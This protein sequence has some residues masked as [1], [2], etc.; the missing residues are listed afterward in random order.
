M[1]KE[2]PRPFESKYTWY[3]ETTDDELKEFDPK[4]VL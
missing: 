2:Y 3:L 4:N 1:L